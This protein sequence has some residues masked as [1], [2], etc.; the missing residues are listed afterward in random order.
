MPLNQQPPAQSALTRGQNA[1]MLHA[2]R[3]AK[4]NN[5]PATGQADARPTASFGRDSFCLSRAERPRRCRFHLDH[6]VGG[7][8]A[9]RPCASQKFSAREFLLIHN[10]RKAARQ[11][12]PE[13]GGCFP[14][15]RDLGLIQL[16]KVTGFGVLRASR[17]GFTR[18]LP[19]L[20]CSFTPRR[21]PSL[22]DARSP[23]SRGT[24]RRIT[25][26][27]PVPQPSL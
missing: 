7:G 17:Q 10:P 18:S 1:T 16:V 15:L 3:Q 13:S 21:N 14:V 2:L 8:T 5:S 12:T 26:Q 23:H 11:C 27:V 25:T 22:V 4:N 19:L 24:C 20:N 6:E 9:E